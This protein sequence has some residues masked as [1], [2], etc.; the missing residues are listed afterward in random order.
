M[1]ILAASHFRSARAH[2][3]VGL[4]YTFSTTTS[5]SSLDHYDK[6]IQYQKVLLEVLPVD[7]TLL[8]LLI[9]LILVLVSYLVCKY[10]RSRRAN[11]ILE[12]ELGDGQRSL[13][14]VL[15]KLTFPA[16]NYKI[17]VDVKA[18][19]L[20]PTE[21]LF[22]AVIDWNASQAVS[23]VNTLLNMPQNI[24][25]R[26]I[27]PFWRLQTLRRILKHEF[28]SVIHVK[29]KTEDIL[30]SVILHSYGRRSAGLFQMSSVA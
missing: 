20:R 1:A 7:V 28:Y 11:T 15:A 21:F 17:E 16:Q 4:H 3:E 30:E 23:C 19:N 25:N 29:T 18:L 5:A 9:L 2:Q 8:F 24:G 22:S 14:W 13:T 10:V 27:V 12:L 6:F 26:V